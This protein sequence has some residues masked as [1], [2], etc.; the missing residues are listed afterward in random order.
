LKL[1]HKLNNFKLLSSSAYTT[2]SPIK[3]LLEVVCQF[4]EYKVISLIDSGATNNFI[5]L[6]NAQKYNLD[7]TNDVKISVKLADGNIVTTCAYTTCEV[8]LGEVYVNLRFEILNADVAVIL[9]MPF[10]EACNPTINWKLK[11]ISIKHK[12]RIFSVPTLSTTQAS[13][14]TQLEPSV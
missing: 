1:G 12:N 4:G 9:G 6:K 14:P 8:K 11:T 5:S 10:L 3:R 2:I 13:N 7:I